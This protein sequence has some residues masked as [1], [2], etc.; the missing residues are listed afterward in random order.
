MEAMNPTG[1]DRSSALAELLIR[2][3]TPAVCHRVW[4]A[5]CSLLGAA[6]PQTGYHAEHHPIL[7]C[8]TWG[9]CLHLIL[10]SSWCSLS[11]GRTIWA[12]QL[13]RTSNT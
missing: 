2:I 11:A 3:L 4:E 13:Q 9:I 12:V 7:D 5:R 1:A 10:S 6:S 8:A